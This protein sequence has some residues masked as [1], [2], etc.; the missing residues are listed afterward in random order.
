MD[1]HDNGGHS[2]YIILFI[3]T[4]Y[5]QKKPFF[6]AITIEASDARPALKNSNYLTYYLRFRL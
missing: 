4:S 6:D 2:P 5:F 3:L 1:D